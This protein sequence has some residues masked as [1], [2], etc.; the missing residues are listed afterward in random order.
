MPAAPGV[1]RRP[2][3]RGPLAREHTAS[4]ADSVER[5]GLATRAALPPQP[6]DL[7]HLLTAAGQKAREAGTERGSAFDSERSPTRCVPVDELQRV[8]IAVTARDN[9]LLEN[10]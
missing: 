8:C 2:G 5:V 3:C 1:H 6:A 4:G 7:E 10:D 9:R